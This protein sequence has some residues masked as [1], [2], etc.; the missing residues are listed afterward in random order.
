MIILGS[1]SMQAIEN[2]V[3][4]YYEL[5]RIIFGHRYRI[6]LSVQMSTNKEYLSQWNQ[7]DIAEC[8]FL[9]VTS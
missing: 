4:A 2:M 3:A 7:Y 6:P 5:Q 8:E 1:R 9:K